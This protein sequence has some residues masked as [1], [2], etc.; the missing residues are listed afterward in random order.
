MEISEIKARLSIGTVLQHYGLQ[1]DRNGMLRCPFHEDATASLKG[2]RNWLNHPISVKPKES[3]RS[4]NQR[5][6]LL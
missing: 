2:F 5:N 4:R 6:E 1:P 3:L